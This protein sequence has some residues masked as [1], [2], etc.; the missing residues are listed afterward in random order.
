MKVFEGEE[1]PCDLLLMVSAL[2]SEECYITTMNLDGETNLKV[3]MG[4]DFSCKDSVLSSFAF[5]NP[6]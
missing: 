5:A 2:D 4:N 6:P 1:F 3:R